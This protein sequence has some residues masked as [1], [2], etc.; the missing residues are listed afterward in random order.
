MEQL[1]DRPAQAQGRTH[2]RHIQAE[3]PMTGAERWKRVWNS[4]R[5]Q[6]RISWRRAEHVCHDAV[7]GRRLAAPISFLAVAAALGLAMT[8]TTLYTPS[9]A[10]YV[11]GQN[12]GVVADQSVVQDV[13]D[14][15]EQEG[16][17][18]LGHYEVENQIDYEF[19]LTLR[20]ELTGQEVFENFFYH[21]L[22][23]TGEDLLKYQVLLNGQ[24]LGVVADQTELDDLLTELKS[25]YINEN[26]IDSGFVDTI[27]VRN[28]YQA[29]SLLEIDTL[30]DVFTA[31]I[32]GETTY[33]VVKG[34][35][36]NAIAYSNNMS[37][38]DLKELNP[39][40]DI[41]K[42]MVGD[43]L[44]IKEEVPLLSVTTTDH[45]TYTEPI[46][47]PVQEV[48]DNTI[49]VGSSKIVT[50]GVEGEALVTADVDFVNGKEVDR[51]ILETS[52]ITEPTVT[53]KAIGTKPKPKTASNGY[54]IWPVS[55]RISSYFGYRNISFA[56]KYHS[57]LD[58]AASMG[59]SIKA[60]DGGKVTF[61]GS[62]G[63][64]GNLVIITHDNGT[65]TY[66]A[67]CS[68]L[69]V[70]VG[71]RVYQGQVIAKVGMTG[72]TSGP[73]VHFEVRIN[74]TAVNPLN[75]LKKR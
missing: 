19:A 55:G 17:A 38:S 18:L 2:G 21:Q 15:V 65:Q 43:V 5:E 56:S 35:T 53:V 75:Y 59:T 7:A 66:Y 10:V 14:S 45:V 74:G 49:Y 47:C 3:Q 63:T 48:E 71:Q 64:Y 69:L 8:L 29:D 57:G 25:A 62:K 6:V 20:T 9:Y 23:E 34:D 52:T 4:L 51:T 36:F 27:T 28:V 30:R 37:V 16:T 1:L 54:Y 44:T 72:R 13:L 31:N 33:T 24:V 12:M 42:L 40:V 73:H 22:E 32:S 61:A 41:N 58:I 67:H 70:S 46:P 11:D 50:Q 26:T 68:T 39:G 60:A